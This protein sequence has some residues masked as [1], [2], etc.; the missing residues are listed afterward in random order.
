[1]NP[2]L[3]DH[4]YDFV[5]NDA[6]QAALVGGYG[7]GKTYTLCAKGLRMAAENPGL[8]GMLVSPTYRMGIDILI[9][10]FKQALEEHGIS[11][12]YRA[13]DYK[14]ILQNGSEVW[15]RS[16]DRP[17]KLKGP[18]LAW[19]ILDEAEL[20]KK[21]V[22]TVSLSRV[23]H[24]KAKHHFV[25]AVSTSGDFGW[26]YDTFVVNHSDDP[27]YYIQHGVSSRENKSLPSDY[28]DTLLDNMTPEEVLA[29]IDGKF[30]VS[31]EG[32]V[33]PG[34]D[35]DFHLIDCDYNKSSVA[36]IGMDFNVH[37]ATAVAC[38]PYTY[39]GKSGLA[40]TRFWT[41]PNSS[42]DAMAEALVQEFGMNVPVYYDH[43]GNNRNHAT[44]ESDKDILKLAGFKS[45]FSKQVKRVKDKFNHLGRA[46]KSA[47]GETLMW[48]GKQ[49]VE[50]ANK[51][52]PSIV[53]C[54]ENARWNDNRTDYDDP[55]Y[56][57]LLDCFAYIAY[58]VYPIKARPVFSGG[59]RATGF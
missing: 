52:F 54:L 56:S 12:H 15:F 58:N 31:K 17:D 11:Y 37:P 21:E 59:V 34:F 51:Q 35:R 42:T 39:K 6:R 55:Q 49:C 44:G 19:A 27:Q 7:S 14:C 29:Y 46:L 18:T 23:R 28:V 25:G 43:T 48:I 33:F 36:C 24:P 38:Q 40:A 9:P 26:L 8:P 30:Y 47:K 41:L 16:A 4:Q 57:H 20:M 53:E 10:S 45:T 32:K 22:W 13:S 1:M 2:K 3:Y 50:R 5:Q